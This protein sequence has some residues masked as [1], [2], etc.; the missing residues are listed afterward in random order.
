MAKSVTTT[1]ARGDLPE[2]I[3]EVRKLGS[4]GNERLLPILFRLK[5]ERI[6]TTAIESGS[7]N[8]AVLIPSVNEVT[9]RKTKR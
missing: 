7:N 4:H 5:M 3:E 6:E 1:Q 2:L 9:P 8:Q